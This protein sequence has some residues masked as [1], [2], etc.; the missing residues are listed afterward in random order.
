M[1]V[2]PGLALLTIVLIPLLIAVGTAIFQRLWNTTMPEVFGLKE[3]TF[4][5]ALKMLI[6]AAFLFGGGR[7]Y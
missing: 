7:L 1:S 4:W 6:L 2:E 5:Q 3:I